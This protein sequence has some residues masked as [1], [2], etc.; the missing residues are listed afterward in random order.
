LFLERSKPPSTLWYSWEMK[1]FK[2]DGY[3][4]LEY[5]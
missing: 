3:K 2:S 5:M 4:I 1:V